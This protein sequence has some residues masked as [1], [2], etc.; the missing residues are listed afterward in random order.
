VKKLTDY[1]SMISKI[2]KFLSL[3]FLK[4][5]LFFKDFILVTFYYLLF[6]FKKLFLQRIKSYKDFEN[7]HNYPNYLQIGY[8]AKYIAPI[9]EIYCKGRGLDIRGGSTPF[10]N[11]KNIDPDF[12]DSKENVYEIFEENNSQDYIFSSHCMEHLARPFKALR[13]FKK[14]LKHNGIIFLYL[15]HPGNELWLKENLN[16]HL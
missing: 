15:P 7:R 9:A 8:A 2:N 12:F 16:F 14:V 1:F 4:K 5:I 3:S 11:S 10:K 6:I 13:E